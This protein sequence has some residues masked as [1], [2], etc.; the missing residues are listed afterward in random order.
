MHTTGRLEKAINGIIDQK[1]HLELVID[2]KPIQELIDLKNRNLVIDIIRQED[3]P[4]RS[5][6]A[7]SYFHVLLG[8]LADKMET[9]RPECKNLILGRYGQR[10][11]DDDGNIIEILVP[12]KINMQFREDIHTVPVGYEEVNGVEMTRYQVSRGSHTL[13]RA[14]MAILINGLV[15]EAK[16]Y[17]IETLTPDELARLNMAWKARKKA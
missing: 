4:K 9:S 2:D 14:E 1:M 15:E 8:K 13:N 17:G 16:E 10:E 7:N 11:F 5:L 6:D 12:S 3:A